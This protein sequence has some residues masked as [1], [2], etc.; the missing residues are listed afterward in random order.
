M[1]TNVSTC[2]TTSL[3]LAKFDHFFSVSSAK[4]LQNNVVHTNGTYNNIFDN[5][6]FS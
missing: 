5:H 1:C 6:T 3:E 4:W 2:I